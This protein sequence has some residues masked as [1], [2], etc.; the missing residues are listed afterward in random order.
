MKANKL[1][2]TALLAAMS[3]L[4][5]GCFVS[6]DGLGGN[7]DGVFASGS[8]TSKPESTAA[9]TDDDNGSA[10]A[11]ADFKES[12]TRISVVDGEINIER[13]SRESEQDMEGDKWTVLLY[14][15]GT[16]LETD[17]GAATTD[18]LE[19]ID[20]E[21]ND[22]VNLIIQTGGTYSWNN[23]AVE[24]GSIQ[25]FELVNGDIKKVDEQG[26]QSMGSSDTLAD[27]VSWAA[28]C[29]PAESM[30]LILWNHGGGS[31]S[32]VCFDELYDSDSLSLRELDAALN[33]YLTSRI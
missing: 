23:N 25:R 19:A 15:C 2:F 31:I 4:L 28:E 26:L 22:D 9:P 13:R 30:G 17:G 10:A 20:A 16:D 5:S 18:L 6:L 14:L 24:S 27:F 8:L 12:G 33:C 11:S 21:Y 32:G 3:V 7:T 29:Y 1:K